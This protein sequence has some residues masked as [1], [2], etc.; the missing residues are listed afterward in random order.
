MTAS[1]RGRVLV[2]QVD[3]Q[4]RSRLPHRVAADIPEF[5]V[6]T[7]TRIAEARF[8]Q[9]RRQPQSALVL[10]LGGGEQRHQ[11]AIEDMPLGL[12]PGLAESQVEHHDRGAEKKEEQHADR[13]QQPGAEGTH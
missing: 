3:A 4:R 12:F 7:R 5:S 8:G 6:K 9:V 11:V 1:L 10:G 13:D 2:R